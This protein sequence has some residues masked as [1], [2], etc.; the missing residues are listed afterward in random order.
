VT[1]W[2]M[3]K[4]GTV[5]RLDRTSAR[6]VELP[7]IGLED[8]AP[9]S[10]KIVGA[11]T[12]RKV[13]SNTFI[14]DDSHVLY[15]RLRPYL[16]KWAVPDYS[17][18]CATEIL[19]IKPNELLLRKYLAYWLSSDAINR[20]IDQSSR[21][22]RMPRANMEEVFRFEIPLP[23]RDE[24]ERIVARLDEASSA[25]IKLTENVEKVEKLE[26]ALWACALNQAT[27]PAPTKWISV[28][29]SEL[30]EIFDG[31]RKPI[32]KSDRD[33]VNIPYYG[34]TGVVDYV[35]DYPFD[36]PLVRLGDVS[37]IIA[38]QSP[39]GRHYNTGQEG[40]PFY[41]GKK[42]FGDRFIKP[43]KTW[44]REYRKVAEKGD[45][46]MSVRAPVGPV[47][48]A[49]ERCAIG[50]GLASIRPT[51]RVETDYIFYYLQSI[52]GKLEYSEGAVFS[53]ISKHQIADIQLPLPPLAE[54]RRI[55]AKLDQI[56]DTLSDLRRMRAAR[57]AALEAFQKS[58]SSCSFSQAV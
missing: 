56:N 16:N 58:F 31:K 42:D 22:A 54:Q 49:I 24:Q 3:V 23:P 13:K 57:T 53:S 10:G 40:L 47:N 17:G 1:A 14:F 2:P 38:G 37:E 18:H 30:V 50:R 29:L 9:G 43:A 28:A 4:L 46:L 35:K 32:T 51:E 19:P 34:A 45:I 11:L 12:P 39:P 52:E 55:A 36:E 44:T 27:E 21:G 8:I 6:D 7:Y 20:R 26:K 25:L 41:Q 33:P 48:M 15:G 5:A